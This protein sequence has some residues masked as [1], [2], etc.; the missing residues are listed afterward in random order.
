MT[1]SKERIRPSRGLKLRRLTKQITWVNNRKLGFN[2]DFQYRYFL[3]YLCSKRPR[4]PKYFWGKVFWNSCTLL[5]QIIVSE[6][7]SSTANLQITWGFPLAFNIDVLSEWTQCMKRKWPWYIFDTFVIPIEELMTW[8][9]ID[10]N[11]VLTCNSQITNK[12]IH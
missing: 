2:I 3:L 8:Y 5:K 1:I 11:C 7:K 10:N 6:V 9:S 4:N 12:I